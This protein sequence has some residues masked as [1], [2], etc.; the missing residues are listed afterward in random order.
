M[1][2]SATQKNH[3]HAE[4]GRHSAPAAP[5]ADGTAVPLCKS[6]I[7]GCA[8]AAVS[9]CAVAGSL[10]LIGLGSFK[11]ADY[12]GRHSNEAGDAMLPDEAKGSGCIEYWLKYLQVQLLSAPCTQQAHSL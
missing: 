6:R 11:Q 7:C 8:A 2:L 3:P 9:C 10:W 1:Q 5:H 4:V 12:H